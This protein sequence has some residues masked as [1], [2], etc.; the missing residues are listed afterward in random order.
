[1]SVWYRCRRCGDETT[2]REPLP[3]HM[4]VCYGGQRVVHVPGSPYAYSYCGGALRVTTITP[5]VAAGGGR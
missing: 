2:Y 4:L 3:D 5:A 1:M